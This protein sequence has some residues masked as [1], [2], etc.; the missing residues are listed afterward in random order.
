MAVYS[1]NHTRNMNTIYGENVGI[2]LLK[3]V[4]R[5]VTTVPDKVKMAALF[6][7]QQGDHQLVKYH[8]LS[9]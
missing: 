3:E 6:T 4:V 7:N 5:T 8:M 1:E 9:A 2:C